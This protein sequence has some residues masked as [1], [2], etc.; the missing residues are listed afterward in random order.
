M[1]ASESMCCRNDLSCNNAAELSGTLSPERL[2]K[3]AVFSRLSSNGRESVAAVLKILRQIET[4][5]VV[6]EC[7]CVLNPAYI[8]LGPRGCLLVVARSRRSPLTM[9][10]ICLM[11]SCLYVHLGIRN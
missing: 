4:S 11:Q 5:L 10:F 2:T 9:K 8:I 3:A 7:L 6:G 1:H